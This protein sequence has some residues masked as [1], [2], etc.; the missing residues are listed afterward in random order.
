MDM[1]SAQEIEEMAKVAWNAQYDRLTEANAEMSG[2]LG[3]WHE[4]SD[5][6]REDWRQFFRDGFSTLLNLRSSA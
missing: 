6:L 3:R 1:P 5:E 2:Y 4:E